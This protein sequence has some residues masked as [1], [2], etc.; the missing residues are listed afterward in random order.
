MDNS[1]KICRKNCHAVK[2]IYLENALDTVKKHLREGDEAETNKNVWRIIQSSTTT[3]LKE[4]RQVAIKMASILIGICLNGP[5]TDDRMN[6]K[7]QIQER[8]DEKIQKKKNLS[9]DPLGNKIVKSA[10]KASVN[11]AFCKKKSSNVA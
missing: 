8:N 11:T 10:K 2:N 7:S 5:V 9:S 1:K 4:L 3:D 6:L